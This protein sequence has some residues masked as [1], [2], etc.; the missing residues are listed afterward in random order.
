MKCAFLSLVL[1]LFVPAFVQA[2]TV[3]YPLPYNID[4]AYDT[5]SGSVSPGPAG[6]LSS[7][8]A[9][10]GTTGAPIGQWISFD[11]NALVN[12]TSLT[13]VNGWAAPEKFN[14]Y[15][16]IK[17]AVLAF[18]GGA[19]EQI[20]L[21]DTDTPQTVAV[22]GKGTKAKLTVT[23]VYPGSVSDVP[24]LSSLRFEGFDPQKVQVQ[25]TGRF[26]GCVRSRSS[27]MGDGT[28]QPL[29]YCVRFH[30]EDGALYGCMDDLCFHPREYMNTRLS[31]VGIVKEGNVL[32]VLQATPIK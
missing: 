3:S 15:G 32:E 19:K 1:M 7:L 18:E 5:T 14:Q 12:V 22:H 29:Y 13:L 11:Y 9:P 4:A 16:R 17:T 25:M 26:E 28:E 23:S 31:M 20:H 27:S 21:K 6:R 2:K 10:G 8:M 24:Y 30:A